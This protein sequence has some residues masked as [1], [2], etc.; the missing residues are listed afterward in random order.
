LKKLYKY[1]FFGIVFIILGLS[2]CTR[3]SSTPIPGTD[4]ASPEVIF[5]VATQLGA[6]LPPVSPFETA[7]SEAVPH[8]QLTPTPIVI[9]DTASAP[10]TVPP[11]QAPEVNVPAATEGL[12]GGC[13]PNVAPYQ[14]LG[15]GQPTFGICGVIQD[16][17]VTIQTNDFIAGQTYT[18]LMGT[19]QSNGVGGVVI[20]TYSA[21]NGGRYAEIYP[22]PDSLKGMSEIAIRIEFSS[23][24]SAWNY[25]FNQTT[26]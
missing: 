12:P 4:T 11:T 22:I 24:W 15:P 17:S 8:T 19:R 2:A 14:G 10:T 18:V 13:T 1:A 6:T 20:G 23:G 5:P 21:N 26:N 7:T 3:V 16:V 25:F 9:V